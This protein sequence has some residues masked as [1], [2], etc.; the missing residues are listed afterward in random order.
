ML[1]GGCPLPVTSVVGRPAGVLAVTL[2]LGCAVRSARAQ[3]HPPAHDMAAMRDSATPM[4]MTGPLGISMGRAGSGTS[5]IPDAVPLP[6][7]HRTAGSWDLMLHGWLFVQYDV[8]QGPRGS[9]QFGSLNWG[10][11]MAGRPLGKGRVTL[12][13]MLSLDPATVTN[14]GYPLLLQN[15]ET[16]KG[17]PIV[18]RQHPHDFFMELAA[19]YAR[20]ISRDVAVSLY[21][22]PSGEPALGPP[23]Y[24][25]R[26]STMDDPAA[27]LGHHWQDATHTS[28][29]VITGGIFTR[30]ARLEGSAFN[31]HET[32][33]ERLGFDPL[34]LGSWSGRLTVNPG[35][36]WSLAASYGYLK[37]HAA[38]HGGAPV[39]LH[40]VAASAI[41]STRLGPGRHVSAALL[42]GSN[43]HQAAPTTRSLIAEVEAVLGLNTVTLRAETVEKTSDDLDLVPAF[44]TGTV[45]RVAEASLGYIRDLGRARGVTLGLGARGTINFV[46]ADLEPAY[47]SRT[48][49]GAFVFVRLR[50]AGR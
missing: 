8:Q 41:Y 39:S 5:W 35:A 30:H 31:G 1:A 10:M 36:H 33:E 7:G 42:Y 22:G 13:T 24:M 37:D 19:E 46:P 17:H 12:R 15:G 49:A 45:F 34:R 43:A 11:L 2:M 20:P 27:P 14:R 18:D 32:D 29:G 28:Y 40:R 38:H 9:D 26:P 50:A 48:P 16:Y 6:G 21:A 25:H 23:A 47:G 3:Q 44:A 4:A